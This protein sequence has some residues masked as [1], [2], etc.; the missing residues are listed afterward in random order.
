MA[1][2]LALSA[3][4]PVAGVVDLMRGKMVLRAEWLLGKWKCGGAGVG[5]RGKGGWVQGVM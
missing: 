5:C 2:T 3:S 4:I 1:A